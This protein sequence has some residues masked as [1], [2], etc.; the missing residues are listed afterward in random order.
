MSNQDPQKKAVEEA[1][2]KEQEENK[3]DLTEARKDRCE[4]VVKKIL[5][6]L[7]D[8][9][10]LLSDID[11]ID[12]C[13]K[14][15]FD[16][17]LKHMVYLHANEVSKMVVDSMSKAVEVARE[18]LWQKNDLGEISVGDVQKVLDKRNQRKS[19]EK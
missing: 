12:Q 6:M 16:A 11:Y 14:D 18:E 4:P 10:L 1:V 17:L 19:G 2:K 8:K 7:L 13:V 9:D 3:V 5:E 15:Q